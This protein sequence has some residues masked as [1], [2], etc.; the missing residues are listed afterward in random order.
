MY[1]NVTLWT[2]NMVCRKFKIYISSFSCT[3]SY[4]AISHM[5]ESNL[6]DIVGPKHMPI[7]SKLS[8]FIAK[9]LDLKVWKNYTIRDF[10]SQT[11]PTM[12]H[13]NNFNSKT[14]WSRKLTFWICSY[15]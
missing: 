9:L 1:L 2:L 15:G 5:N 7:I 13:E 14:I 4:E 11:G 3:C 12:Y 6:H 8:I 10:C